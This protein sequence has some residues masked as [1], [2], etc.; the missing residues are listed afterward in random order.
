VTAREL[1]A[2]ATPVQPAEVYLALRLQLEAQIGA[3]Q[4]RAGVTI[5]VGQ[6]ALETGRFKASQNFNLGGIK[7]SGKWSG[8]WQHFAT[9]EVLPRAAA[10]K[11]MRE[12]PAGATVA[13]VHDGGERV[14]LKFSGRHPVNKF[15][16]FE[17]LDAAVEHHVAF[18]LGRYRTAVAIAMLGNAQ[19]YADELYRLGYYTGDREAYGK[20]VASL[21]REYD[22][23]LPPDAPPAAPTSPVIEPVSIAA[24]L[25]ADE[26]R[27]PRHEPPAPPATPPLATVALPR[28]GEPAPIEQ[29][30]WFVRFFFWFVRLFLRA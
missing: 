16:A 24:S 5:L 14:T 20:S 2:K 28:I 9:L 4:P 6:M 17:S 15:V 23:T 8:C 11:Y 25:P 21:G 12:V 26:V 1:P 3:P 27:A 22:R 29:V 7:C 19:G 10:E 13:I 30:P 18:L